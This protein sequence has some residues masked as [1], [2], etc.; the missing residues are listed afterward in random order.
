MTGGRFDFDDGG[1]YCGGWE[2]GKAHGHGICTGPKG[3]GEYAGSWSHGFEIVGVYTWPSGN[4]YQGYWSQGKRHGLGVET[5]GKW[6][7]RGE[8]SHGFKGRYGVRQSTNTP[9]RYDGTWSNG[10]QDGYGVETYGDGGTYQGQWMGGM[11][12]GYGVRQSVPYGMAT[13][14][15]SPLRTS[16]ASLRSVQSNG[17]VLQDAIPDTPVGSRGG[18]V[19]NFH[20]DTE[21]VTGKKKGLFRRGSL[22]GSL[23]QL[24]KS[25]SKTSISSKRSSAR[26]DATMSRI[27]SSDAN[28]TISY[29]DGEV[30]DEYTPMEDH[31][32]ATTTESYMGEWK[33]DK[34]NGFG[35]SERSNGL[36]YE[37]EWMNNKRH[38]YGC[39]I[40]PDGT[41]EEGK[42]KNNVLVRGIRKQLIPLKNNKTKEK[43]DRA[44]EGARRAAAIARTKVEIAVSRTSHARTKSEAADQAALASCQE[45]D[46]ARAVARELSPSFHQPGLDYIKQQFSEPV[47]EIKEEAPKEEKEKPSGSPFY[48]RGTTPSHSPVQSP[49]PSPPHSPQQSQAPNPSASRKI[50]KDNSSVAHKISKDSS[51]VAR[52]ISKEERA[53]IVAEITKVSAPPPVPAIKL[54]DV[55]PPKPSKAPE[56]LPKPASTGNGQVHSAYHSYYVKPVMKLP[57]PEEP[58][59]EEPE[60]T[61]SS[62]ARMPPPPK[63]V[64]TPSPKPEPKI[65]KQESIKPKSLAETKKASIDMAEETLAEESGP[66]SILVAMVMLLNIGL[67]I[68]FVHFLT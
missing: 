37:G 52:K 57:P 49:T 39:T 64:R 63:M 7:Y 31:V 27:S 32:D 35:V 14:I 19:L 38:G 48:R 8:W 6:V 41:K 54:Q 13:I 17:A 68:I 47:E 60:M 23:R 59:D 67:A 66:N 12:H 20:S 9:A 18:F 55:P 1:T 28:S 45:S 25:D 53:S 4:T 65:R 10:L 36:K 2:D 34:R 24:R 11:R 43:V 3:Q 50:S 56:P 44:V 21:V 33:N 16:L 29:G 51:S 40:F 30:P 62:L 22:F 46:L 15:R 5:K 58:E 26:S 42:Y 61:Q